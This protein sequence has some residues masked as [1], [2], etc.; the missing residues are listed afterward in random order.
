M[1]NMLCTKLNILG[2]SFQKIFLKIICKEKEE[3]MIKESRRPKM[4]FRASVNINKHF[5]G[6]SA[7]SLVIPS[8]CLNDRKQ[9]FLA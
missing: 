7:V 2:P 1:N 5:I 4:N 6:R 3:K 8:L 9:N